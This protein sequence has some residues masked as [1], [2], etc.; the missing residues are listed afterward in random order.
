VA[1]EAAFPPE[2]TAG[3][4][5]SQ[6][7]LHMS[8][9][10]LFWWRAILPPFGIKLRTPT[11]TILPQRSLTE[12]TGL[13]FNERLQFRKYGLVGEIAGKCVFRAGGS[14]MLVMIKEAI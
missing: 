9:A 12:K 11:P 3:R 4:I 10:V 2:S 13:P 8:F 5:I 14:R 7:Q 6:F 1:G